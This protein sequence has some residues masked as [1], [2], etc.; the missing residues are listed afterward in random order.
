MIEFVSDLKPR[1]MAHRCGDALERRP[2]ASMLK[3]L[4]L[5]ERPLARDCYEPGHFTASGIVA[6]PDGD[7]LLMIRHAKLRLWLQPGGHLEPGDS[8]VVDTVAREV[9]EETGLRDVDWG[10]GAIVHVD[11]H[12]I[13]AQRGEPDHEHY[14]VRIAGRAN[15]WKVRAESDAT[16]VR[17]WP[18]AEISPETSDA[19]V[20]R[21]LMAG[22][23]YL[24]RGRSGPLARFG[25]LGFTG[26]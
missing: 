13:P 11:I 1:L 12:R 24:A 4:A 10:D 3:L 7:A 20:V 22:S 16:D 26:E 9:A 19:S 21:A 2:L 23:H 25:G 17:W 5:G 14:D 6:S 8:T 18:L 15:S